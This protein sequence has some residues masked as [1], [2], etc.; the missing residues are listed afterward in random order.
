M[1]FGVKT[2]KL[3]FEGVD[4]LEV[5]RLGLGSALVKSLLNFLFGLFDFSDDFLDHDGVLGFNEREKFF[6]DEDLIVENFF[7]LRFGV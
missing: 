6:P 1:V 7:R 3:F 2:S 4:F 5:F